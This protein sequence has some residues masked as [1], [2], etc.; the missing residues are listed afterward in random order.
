MLPGLQ[1]DHRIDIGTDDLGFRKVLGE[2]DAFLSGRAP[3]ENAARLGCGGG[4]SG[5]ISGY[6]LSAVRSAL[7]AAGMPQRGHL[8]ESCVALNVMK[9][10]FST[11]TAPEML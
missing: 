5:E 4:S 10:C 8:R 7:V 1:Q 3:E 9:R 11:H 2:R 6:R